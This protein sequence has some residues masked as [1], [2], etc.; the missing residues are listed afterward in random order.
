MFPHSAVFVV[1][2]EDPLR[3]SIE[4]TFAALQPLGGFGSEPATIKIELFYLFEPSLHLFQLDVVFFELVLGEVLHGRFFG[5]FGFE[6]ITFVD[7]FSIGIVPVGLE[8][9]NDFALLPSIESDG[10]QNDRITTHLG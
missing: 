4:Q 3:V 10:L 9:G 2:V 5:D 6:I 7:E 1:R 8:A